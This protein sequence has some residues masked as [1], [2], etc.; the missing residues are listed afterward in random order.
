HRFPKVVLGYAA[1]FV[2]VLLIG[3]GAP[4]VTKKALSAGVGGA[5]TFR[6]IFFALTFFSIG[7]VSNFRKLKEEGMG[8]LALVYLIC[9]FGFIIWI[10][11]FI[12]WVFFH[13][14]TPPKV[15]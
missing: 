8:R 4:E 5:D 7:L 2:L 11:L 13:G 3:A 10:G 9:L 6:G 1:T 12:S 14:I 15:G